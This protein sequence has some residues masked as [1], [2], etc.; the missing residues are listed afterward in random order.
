MLVVTTAAV[1][2]FSVL[3]APAA[4]SA[5]APAASATHRVS[6]RRQI[7]LDRRIEIADDARR[8]PALQKSW[9]WPGDRLT[10]WS[11]LADDYGWTLRTAVKAW[12]RTGLDMTLV[13]TRKKR[14][15]DVLISAVPGSDMAGE[16]ITESTLGGRATRAW[17]KM[18]RDAFSSPDSP[19]IDEWHLKVVMARILAHEFG[20][21]LG[22]DRHE[23]ESHTCGLMEATHD[24]DACADVPSPGNFKCGMVD[25]WVMSRLIKKYGGRGS[26]GPTVCP[27]LPEPSALAGVRIS[28]G[29]DE[30]A[31]VSVAWQVPQAADGNRVELVVGRE[32][33][34]IGF[35]KHGAAEWDTT[36]AEV[37]LLDPAAGSWTQPAPREVENLCYAVRLV[38]EAGAGRAT[39]TSW[40]TSYVP[41]PPAPQ[42]L[43]VEPYGPNSF[44]VRFVPSAYLDDDDYY[45]VFVDP[46]GQCRAS[47]TW[48]DILANPGTTTASLQD[49]GTATL[50]IWT[51]GVSACLSLVAYRYAASP[52]L[53]SPATAVETP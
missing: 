26:L 46:P 50:T 31:K 13:Q 10:Y 36:K 42:V 45:E 5:S 43:S 12:N 1:L 18:S 34:P 19:S 22:Q 21:V 6:E 24:V 28:G 53:L 37:H 52:P 2:A 44:I 30:A 29:M 51:G 20:H 25:K 9:K 39:T 11:G 23:P 32:C 38:N 41:S 7:S 47:V 3:P 15:A 17:I 14:S 40:R 4:T 27:L 16:T 35:D 8:Q 48:D 33:S 49:D